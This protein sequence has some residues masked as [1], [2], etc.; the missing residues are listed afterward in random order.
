MSDTGAP[1]YED[2]ANTTTDA[3]QNGEGALPTDQSGIRRE[4]GDVDPDRKALLK[5]VCKG[6]TEARAY[7]K[8]DFNRMKKDQDFLL[9]LQYMGQTSIDD[10]DRYI[11][12]IVQRHVQQRTAAVYAKNP[13]VV[14]RRKE[15]LDFVIWDENPLTYQMASQAIAMAGQISQKAQMGDEAAKQQ[16][17]QAANNE[18]VKGELAAATALLQDI[19]QGMQRRNVATRI[20]KTMEIYFKNTVLSQQQPPFKTSMKQLVRRT[21]AAGVGYLK[22]GVVRDMEPSPDVFNGMASTQEELQNIDAMLA[23][24]ADGK[25]DGDALCSRKEELRLALQALQARPHIVTQEGLVFDF[26]SATSIIPDKN[27][28]HLAGFLGCQR[29]TEEFLLTADQ[30]EA[31]WK[32][33]VRGKAT[34]YNAKDA[35]PE[36]GYAAM[37]DAVAQKDNGG[38]YCVW[39]TY[40]RSVG[41]VYTSCEGYGDFLEEPA[42]PKL[43]LERF[44]PWFALAF[45]YIEHHKQRFPLSDIHLLKHP[46]REYN[47]AS[48]ARRGHRIANRPLT[49]VGGVLDEADKQKLMDRP[50]NAVVTLTGMAPG[51]KAQDLLQPYQHPPMDPQVYETDHVFQDV[52]RVVGSQEANLGGTS[53][54]TATESSIAESS[55]MSSLQ[56]NM[57]DMDDFLT[58][59]MRA[60]GQIALMEIDADTVKKAVG[61]GAVWPT[62]TGEDIADEIFL[63][64]QAGSSGRPNKAVEV[65]NFTQMLPFLL[66]IPGMSPEW[67]ARQA[68]T[69]MDDRLDMTDAFIAGN[70]SIQTLNAMA[71]KPLGQAP[72][73]AGKPG[74]PGTEDP[75]A[76][77]AEGSDNAAEGPAGGGGALGA[78]P[79]NAAPPVMPQAG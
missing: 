57:D 54:A 6:V 72:Q 19:Q 60:A 43:T 55:R 31:V 59:V 67:L 74:G 8:D 32:V 42:A 45:N 53:N 14:A 33:D 40:D 68:I 39:M 52:L 10:D 38:K 64:I 76:Q 17:L 78:Q 21:M 44:F 1:D 70:P 77:G 46:Q 4:V 26:P 22:V 20:S 41:V 58:E 3:S 71:A 79:G 61:P 65:Q 9:G 63:E 56:S 25:Y 34:A 69:R 27:L 24:N 51:Q 18:Q 12:N 30:I 5:A 75:E 62:L 66:Q 37:R 2:I 23:D 7:W 28:I 49:I 16:A 36:N 35:L 13:T 50:D 11:A 15:S 29:V 73:G 47:R 48:E